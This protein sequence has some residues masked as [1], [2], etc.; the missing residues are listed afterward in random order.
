MSDDPNIVE[1]HGGNHASHSADL[2]VVGAGGGGTVEVAD[3]RGANALNRQ[4]GQMTVLEATK[5]VARPE[6]IEH[7]LATCMKL[8]DSSKGAY[9]RSGVRLYLQ[10]A[11]TLKDLLTELRLQ[12]EAQPGGMT[13]TEGLTISKATKIIQEVTLKQ[14][15]PIPPPEG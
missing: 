12:Q 7:T 9:Q 2:A 13:M 3:R 8:Q 11:K 4:V 6:H 1:E 15:A 10:I 14:T 5:W